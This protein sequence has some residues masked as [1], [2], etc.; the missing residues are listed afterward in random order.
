MGK[1][2]WRIK[3]GKL[4]RLYARDAIWASAPVRGRS[5][6]YEGNF[7]PQL[8]RR[9]PHRRW[10]LRILAELRRS[11][12]PPELAQQQRQPCCTHPEK[13]KKK[14]RTAYTGV[15][16]LAFIE[17]LSGLGF[18]SCRFFLDLEVFLP[19]LFPFDRV[20]KDDQQIEDN[21]DRGQDEQIRGDAAAESEQLTI[22][23][24]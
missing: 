5:P 1:T 7:R 19:Q 4:I 3:F 14:T 6:E 23:I 12:C 22:G 13:K 21:Q 9:S 16:V 18:Q 10:Q 8:R 17:F 11:R 15:R 2:Y 20:E 24:D